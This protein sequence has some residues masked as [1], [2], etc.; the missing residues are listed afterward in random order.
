ML[1]LRT[2]KLHDIGVSPDVFDSYVVM[3]LPMFILT[4]FDMWDG[5]LQFCHLNI[6]EGIFLKLDLYDKNN[7]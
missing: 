2:E 6:G 3:M 5:L 4:F 7:L 1:Y